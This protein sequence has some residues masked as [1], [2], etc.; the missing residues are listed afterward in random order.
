[1]STEP[2]KDGS[3]LGGDSFWDE[4]AKRLDES[5]DEGAAGAGGAAA[6]EGS[7]EDG[8]T[9]PDDLALLRTR[10]GRIQQVCELGFA[11]LMGTHS[12]VGL[13]SPIQLLLQAKSG[14]K[15]TAVQILQKVCLNVAVDDEGEYRN[16][17]L[18][19]GGDIRAYS[20]EQRIGSGTYG[21]V[22]RGVH[23]NTGFVVAIKALDKARIKEQGMTD[24]V[25]R[26][27]RI[28]QLLSSDGHPHVVRLFEFIE[29]PSKFFMVMTHCPG[30][31]F[32]DFLAY[33]G[34]VT[35]S[36]ARA[37][38][39]QILSGVE[40]CHNHFVVH[41]DLKPENLLIDGDC[42]VKIADFSLANLVQGN[43]R[44]EGD[45]FL[46]TSC[47]SPNYAAPEIVSGV[48]YSGYQVDIWSMGVILYSLVCGI[49][50]FDDDNPIILFRQIKSGQYPPPPAHVSADCVALL[51]AMLTVEPKHRPTI[52]QIRANSWCQYDDFVCR[53]SIFAYAPYE[54]PDGGDSDD[55]DAELQELLMDSRRVRA[56]SQTSI[57]EES[58]DN[59]PGELQIYY[60]SKWKKTFLHHTIKG[61]SAWMPLPGEAM[62]KSTHPSFPSPPWRYLE[63]QREK[64]GHQGIKFAFNDG[65]GNWDNRGG[66]FNNYHV[67]LPGTYW[68]DDV[69]DPKEKQVVSVQDRL[70]T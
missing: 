18:K 69:S 66:P 63:V 8:S 40:F 23:K 11:F 1:M 13:N 53:R 36:E 6:S 55:S 17:T 38:F 26:E 5:Y 47:G 19:S 45:D 50:P 60:K 28:L 48:S 31:D 44:H 64:W 16:V 29:T 52:P 43:T 70:P 7:A 3:G 27:T 58:L 4:L 59:K 9:A 25:S 22:Y 12:R 39:L 37:L 56:S 14:G 65:S 51:A 33:R 32:F 41:R 67:D 42:N 46:K 24:K 15:D 57:K 30:G 2:D 21:K 61:D 10:S 34:H 54:N 62:G 49:L 68:I 20:F 35:E